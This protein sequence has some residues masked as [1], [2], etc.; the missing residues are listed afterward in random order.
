MTRI[1]VDEI[2]AKNLKKHDHVLQIFENGISTYIF[3]CILG[4]K[5]KGKS[6]ISWREG[7]YRELK[8]QEMLHDIYLYRNE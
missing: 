5:N 4:E 1:T 6:T 8:K 3:L 7:I 2:K